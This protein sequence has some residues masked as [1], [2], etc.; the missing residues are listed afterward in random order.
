M[1]KKCHCRNGRCFWNKDHISFFS[2]LCRTSV[3]EYYWRH[4]EI[5]SAVSAAWAVVWVV[6]SIQLYFISFQW[7]VIYLLRTL[8]SPILGWHGVSSSFLF[9]LKPEQPKQIQTLTVFLCLESKLPW[10]GR[11]TG[12]VSLQMEIIV[13]FDESFSNILQ[14]WGEGGWLVQLRV[15]ASRSSGKVN[16]T[17]QF[18]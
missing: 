7:F 3:L 4:F 9:L 10:T 15:T 12:R 17:L 11:G 2:H 13:L 14:P 16:E 18:P 6:S 8:T 5:T 1:H